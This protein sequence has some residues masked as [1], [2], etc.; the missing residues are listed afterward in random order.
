M[1]QLRLYVYFLLKQ[2]D[3]VTLQ[4]PVFL[5]L[6]CKQTNVIY[7][8]V[9]HCLCQCVSTVDLCF[10]FPS[11]V[12]CSHLWDN[13]NHISDVRCNHTASITATTKATTTAATSRVNNAVQSTTPAEDKTDRKA[14][15]Q[16]QHRFHPF[17]PTTDLN[18]FVVIVKKTGRVTAVECKL[19]S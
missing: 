1:D 13:H 12:I 19:P 16:K 11:W 17:S 6:R 4:H 8:R 14:V 10:Q 3:R 7:S 18:V 5:H 9:N 15:S 2:V